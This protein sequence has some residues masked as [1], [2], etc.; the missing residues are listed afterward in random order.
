[1]ATL[2]MS[3]NYGFRQLALDGAAGVVDVDEANDSSSIP[4]YADFCR[5]FS[6]NCETRL[7]HVILSE[8]DDLILSCTF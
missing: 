6:L 7:L 8:R 5:S 1:M 4:H 2:Y 3:K